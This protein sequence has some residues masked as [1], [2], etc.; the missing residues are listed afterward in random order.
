MLVQPLDVRKEDPW[1]TTCLMLR[2]IGR[3][4]VDPLHECRNRFL[5]ALHSLGILNA[6][7]LETYLSAFLVFSILG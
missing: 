6:L 3:K 5:I 4:V 7:T 1:Y 2:G